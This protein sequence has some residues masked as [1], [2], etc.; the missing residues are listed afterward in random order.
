MDIYLPSCNFTAARPEA[1]RKIKAYLTSRDIQVAG[2]CRPTQKLL[3]SEDRVISICQTCS[4][5]TREAS[6]QAS[7]ISLW[8][9]LLTDNDFPWPDFQGEE[10]TIQDCWRARHKPALL[11]AVRL[12]MEKMNLR[13]VELAENRENTQFDGVWR[14][15]P[16]AKKNLEIAPNYFGEVAATGLELLSP[17][18]QKVRMEAWVSQYT[19]SRVAV[20]CTACLKGAELGGAHA[21]H[22]LELLTANL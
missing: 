21:V 4:A 9:Y 17:E 12:C 7:E 16:V 6:P 8:E 20:Y 22:L 11:D 18:E 5:I 19:T 3:T 15:Q 14:F 1:S 13:P 2:C 10:M